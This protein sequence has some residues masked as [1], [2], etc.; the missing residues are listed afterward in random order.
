MR[1]IRCYGNLGIVDVCRVGA[2]ALYR[3]RYPR[4]GTIHLPP[5]GYL[6]SHDRHLPTSG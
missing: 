1:V 6:R 3:T 4:S 2:A 5:S